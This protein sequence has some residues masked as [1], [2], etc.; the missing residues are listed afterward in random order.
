MQEIWKDIEGYEGIYRVSNLGR[1]YSYHSNKIL[2]QR[3]HNDYLYI[4]LSKES[5][6]KTFRA[7]RLVAKAFVFNSNPSKNKIINHINCIKT[8]N[9]AENLEWCT[10]KENI[11]HA[12]KNNLRS[13][14]RQKS[15]KIIKKIYQYNK[16]GELINVFESGYEASK[17]TSIAPSGIYYCCTG[18]DK[19]GKRKTAG[20]YIWKYAD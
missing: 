12:I 9:R 8:D 3:V 11:Q 18:K 2:K 14:K 17:K 19:K 13:G 4:N 16:K 15:S 5:S 20:G 6:R 1:I 7:H 10:P